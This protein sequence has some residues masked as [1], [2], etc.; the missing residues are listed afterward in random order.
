MTPGVAVAWLSLAVIAAG[1]AVAYATGDV[2][3]I[4]GGLIT[5]WGPWCVAGF[6]A[7]LRRR[8]RARCAR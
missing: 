4:V 5:G 1:G 6:V 8:R 3:W 2:R 7:Y